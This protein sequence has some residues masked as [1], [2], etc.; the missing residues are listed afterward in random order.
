MECIYRYVREAT[1]N[2]AKTLMSKLSGHGVKLVLPSLLAALNEDSWRTKCG[3]VDLL[4]R[5]A[6]CAPKQ[7]SG[8]LPMIVPRLIEVL[9]DSH[10]KVQESAAKALGVIGSVIRNP[11]IQSVVKILLDVSKRVG[12]PVE[13][14]VCTYQNLAKCFRLCKILARKHRT[15]CKHY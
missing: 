2:T 6:Y 1:D 15:V 9:G 3:S 4:G 12:I 10:V 5:M 8:C 14:L 13:F 7:L 11:E